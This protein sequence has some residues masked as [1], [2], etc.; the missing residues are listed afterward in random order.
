MRLDVLDANARLIPVRMPAL[1][2][3]TT[4][5]E[6]RLDLTHLSSGQYYLRY[7]SEKL[8]ETFRFVKL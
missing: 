1:A 4:T 3:S 6:V 7:Q 5:Y 2:Q 8:V